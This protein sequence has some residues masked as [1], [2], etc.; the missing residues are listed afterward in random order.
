MVSGCDGV[1]DGFTSLKIV[2]K[3]CSQLSRVNCPPDNPKWPASSAAQPPEGAGPVLFQGLEV[4]PARNAGQGAQQEG[5]TLAAAPVD[6][7]D[8]QPS[9]PVWPTRRVRPGG[10]KSGE[11]V[12]PAWGLG[13]VP[14]DGRVSLELVLQ[15]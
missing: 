9:R 12:P 6:H 4:K 5:L 2:L 10:G 1:S 14:A 8:L 3:P 13:T 7:S 11:I 15:P